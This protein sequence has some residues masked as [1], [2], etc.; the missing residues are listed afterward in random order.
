MNWEAALCHVQSVSTPGVPPG[1][2]VTWLLTA[3]PPVSPT[4]PLTHQFLRAPVPV[5]VLA[6]PDPSP[7]HNS[8][9]LSLLFSQSS[10]VKCTGGLEFKA[11]L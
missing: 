3:L 10:E 4:L 1:P 5:S 9:K 11:S 6:V 2:L 7:D 8:L